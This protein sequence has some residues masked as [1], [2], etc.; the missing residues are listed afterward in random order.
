MNDEISGRMFDQGRA[1]DRSG[2]I[3]GTFTKTDGI[4]GK[5]IVISGTIVKTGVEIGELISSHGTMAF[6]LIRLD[7]LDEVT[8]EVI[9]AQI[10]V[11]LHRPAWLAG[12]QM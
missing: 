10:P 2:R 1:P 3:G 7:R 8:G 6:A 5:I 9:A 11:A 4:S 12:A